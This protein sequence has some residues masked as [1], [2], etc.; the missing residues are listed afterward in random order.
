MPPASQPHGE[1]LPKPRRGD[2]TNRVPVV[3][4]YRRDPYSL[5][6]P[7][8]LTSI[9]V[10]GEDILPRVPAAVAA[11]PQ[12]PKCRFGDSCSRHTASR[13]CQCAQGDHDIY[14]QPHA[15]SLE[16]QRLVPGCFRD[17][18][19]EKERAERFGKGYRQPALT[20]STEAQSADV[21]E[22]HKKYV[23]DVKRADVYLSYLVA[24]HVADERTCL[25]VTSGSCA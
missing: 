21:V 23:K 19:I 15:G 1:R 8:C 9:K 4:R 10:R 17:R 12:P 24:C 25:L 6:S 20:G 13:G 5:H 7:I 3:A 16:V 11:A 18:L 2:T 14:R 22:A